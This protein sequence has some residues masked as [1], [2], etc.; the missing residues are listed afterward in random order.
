MISIDLYK[1]ISDLINAAQARGEDIV[2]YIDQMETDL[3]NSEIP[4]VDIE[5]QR[6][7]SQISATS[8]LL[9]SR[10]NAY[11]TQ[12]LNFVFKLQTYINNNYSSVNDFLAD[13]NIKVK[14]IFADISNEVGFPIDSSNIEGGSPSG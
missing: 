7:E 13:S 12:M 14:S 11:T 4:S 1:T 5:R 9:E 8:N 3:T 2:S 10:H 6:L